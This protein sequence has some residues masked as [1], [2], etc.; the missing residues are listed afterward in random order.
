VPKKVLLQGI[1]YRGLTWSFRE[2]EV[3]ECVITEAGHH[4]T[5]Y[6]LLE[7]AP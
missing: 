1:N 7:A 6:A 2:S 3:G 5:R 4:R